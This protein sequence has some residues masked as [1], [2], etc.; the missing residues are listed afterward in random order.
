MDSLGYLPTCEGQGIMEIEA[1][2]R[3]LLRRLVADEVKGS[4]PPSLSEWFKRCDQTEC[5]L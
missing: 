3:G 5:Y 2:S 4:Y 1:P